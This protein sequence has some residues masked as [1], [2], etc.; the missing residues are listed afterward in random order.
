MASQNYWFALVAASLLLLLIDLAKT[1]SF[2][3]LLSVFFALLTA[4]TLKEEQIEPI[5]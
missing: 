5:K 3:V 1:G 4:D 2:F